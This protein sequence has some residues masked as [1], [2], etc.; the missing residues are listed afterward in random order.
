MYSLCCCSRIIGW[1][2]HKYNFCR[3]QCFVGTNVLSRQTCVL[4]RQNV[5]V[6]GAVW[7]QVRSDGIML[8]FLVLVFLLVLLPPPPPTPPAS[9]PFL[10]QQKTCVCRR[11]KY[12][13]P[14]CCTVVWGG[15]DSGALNDL[16][17]SP[18]A[19]NQPGVDATYVNVPCPS[20]VPS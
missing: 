9:I 17:R 12:M 20:S 18:A 14:K 6:G 1:S 7:L 2:C 11:Q 16:N 10:S 3:D 15:P 19:A 4:W 8:M 13:Q 5:S